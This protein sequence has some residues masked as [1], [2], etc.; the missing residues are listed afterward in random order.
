MSLISSALHNSLNELQ[1]GDGAVPCDVLGVYDV[2][3]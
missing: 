2:C 1:E 3:M